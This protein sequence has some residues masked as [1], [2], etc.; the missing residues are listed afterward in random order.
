MSEQ[1]S[2]AKKPMANGSPDPEDMLDIEVGKSAPALPT[3][4][5]QV[6][7][8]IEEQV[9]TA[10]NAEDNLLSTAD[11]ESQPTILELQPAAPPQPVD[12]TNGADSGPREFPPGE[13]VITTIAYPPVLQS[14]VTSR[15]VSEGTTNEA[16]PWAGAYQ[17]V[18][19]PV[20]ETPS[21]NWLALIARETLETVVLAVVIF[22]LIRVAVQNYRI[23]GSSMEP[24]FHNGEYLLVNKLAYRLGEYQR[25]DVIVFKYPGDITK[26][27]IKRV[28]GLPGDVVE[29]R[30][31]VLY[32]NEQMIDEPYATMPMNFL[33]EP[34]RI[35]E[36]GTLYVMGDNRPASSD[37]RDW[38]LLNQD[39]VIGQAWLAI[40]PLETFGLVDHP[41]LHFTPGMAQGP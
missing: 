41:D 5:E 14:A 20:E 38:G 3:A 12:S 36:S 10:P 1:N 39:L 24:N 37:T 19:A 17:P 6:E 32:V 35:V 7:E 4:Q 2:E 29:I 11:A 26:D 13:P 9:D 28:I 23:E 25:G 16:E 40:F 33:N 18:T 30:E 31:G 21:E 34:P 15:P 8:Q 22:L 27:Y